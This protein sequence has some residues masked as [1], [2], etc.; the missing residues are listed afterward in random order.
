MMTCINK[1][2]GC[3][4]LT[5]YEKLSSHEIQCPFNKFNTCG[6]EHRLSVAK[7][8]SPCPLE[9]DNKGLYQLHGEENHFCG[10][11]LKDAADGYEERLGSLTTENNELRRLIQEVHRDMKEEVEDSETQISTLD[12]QTAH[13]TSIAA[14]EK[15]YFEGKIKD[16]EAVSQSTHK[17]LKTE[18]ESRAIAFWKFIASEIDRLK[19]SME[20]SSVDFLTRVNVLMEDYRIAMEDEAQVSVREDQ[21]ISL[22][23]STIKGKGT[24]GKST[25][26]S[27]VEKTVT[28]KPFKSK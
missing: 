20:T 3:L 9:I 4:K 12:K 23:L 10:E 17:I 25:V 18:A 19:A 8:H 11:W 26:H 7:S 5:S 16:L 1:S 22:L 14:K 2:H 24:T 27:T 21:G 13:Y 15:A 28:T 6:K